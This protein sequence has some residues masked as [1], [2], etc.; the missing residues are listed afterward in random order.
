MKIQLYFIICTSGNVSLWIILFRGHNKNIHQYL[1]P[2]EYI[3]DV[4]NKDFNINNKYKQI[5]L[6]I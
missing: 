1:S 2:K 6:K 5:K 3:Y 4:K